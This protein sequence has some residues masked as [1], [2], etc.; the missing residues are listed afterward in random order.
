MTGSGL[1]TD[2]EATFRRTKLK[3]AILMYQLYSKES[4]LSFLSCTIHWSETPMCIMTFKPHVS[5]FLTFFDV[6]PVTTKWDQI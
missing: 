6:V 1:R 3:L 2:V 4:Q 5:I